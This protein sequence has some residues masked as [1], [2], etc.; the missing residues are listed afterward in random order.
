MIIGGPGAGKTFLAG[1]LGRILGLPVISVDD[2]V[3]DQAGR[4]RPA[5]DIDADC[6]AA[7]DGS[8][9]IIEGGNSRT[10]DYRAARADCLIRLTPAR[11]QRLWRVLRR[12]G[13]NWRLLFWTMR[14]DRVFGPRDRAVVAMMGNGTLGVELNSETDVETFLAT[15][16]QKSRPHRPSA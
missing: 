1:A 4:L 10:Y 2:F 16:A 7:A 8:S 5:G 14:Y 6:R 12:D 15:F 3:H 9:W 11:W 13:W